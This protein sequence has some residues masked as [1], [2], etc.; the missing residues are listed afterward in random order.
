MVKTK[1]YFRTSFHDC[2][3]LGRNSKR[4]KKIQLLSLLILSTIL[5]LGHCGCGEGYY[6]TEEG[7]CERCGRG[8]YC[9]ANS[10]EPIPCPVGTY[11]PH[12]VAWSEEHCYPCQPGTYSNLELRVAPHVDKVIIVLLGLS[13]L[14][15]VQLGSYLKE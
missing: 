11:C 5:V 8:N 1:W 2:Q 4:L 7:D 13:T 15:L 9:P 14:H 10:T 3:T 6:K 12:Y